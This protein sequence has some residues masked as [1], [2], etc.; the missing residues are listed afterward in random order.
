MQGNNFS[1]V[2]S[3]CN[4]VLDPDRVRAQLASQ[5]GGADVVFDEKGQRIGGARLLAVV[6]VKSGEV[7]QHFDPNNPLTPKTHEAIQDMAR[8]IKGSLK[9]VT[10]IT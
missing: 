1:G 7:G 4:R 2:V 6:T 3:Y 8:K 10:S 9:I 5:R